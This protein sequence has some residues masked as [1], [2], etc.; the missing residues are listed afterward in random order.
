MS[1]FDFSLSLNGIQEPLMYVTRHT[2]NA[3]QNAH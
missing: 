1:L 3:E 2:Q